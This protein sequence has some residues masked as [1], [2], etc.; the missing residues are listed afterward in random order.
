MKGE[1][2]VVPDPLALAAEGAERILASAE[3]ALRV[4]GAFHVALAGGRTPRAAYREVAE[5]AGNGAGWHLWLGDE[6]FVPPEH[7]ASNQRMVRES[8][9]A[10]GALPE[11]EF[12]APRTASG[13]PQTAAEGYARALEAALPDPPRLDLVLL[14]MGPDG[15]TAS[16]FPGSPAL[17]AAE[18]VVAVPAPESGSAEGFP[19]VTLT[20]PVLNA[21][22]RVVFLVSGADKRRALSSVVAGRVDLP[23]GRVRPTRGELLWLV[24]AAAGAGLEPDSA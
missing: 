5:R 2:R 3:E 7:P 24:D 22:R 11:A 23:A 6:R 18:W 20:L 9:L 12:R 16:L 10:R 13:S 14:G 15:H 1:L 4:R 8:L 17:E 21:A 19:R